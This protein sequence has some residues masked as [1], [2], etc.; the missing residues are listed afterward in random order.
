MARATVRRTPPRP[1]SSHDRLLPFAGVAEGSSA[2]SV[3]PSRGPVDTS[4]H[5]HPVAQLQEEALLS[6]RQ[7]AVDD[8]VHA[9]V[10]ILDRFA[11]LSVA[12]FARVRD[13]PLLRFR[14][15]GVST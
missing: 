15:L 1:A 10:R 11:F 12:A 14:L 3:C 6:G 5:A 9:L 4:H 7:H 13:G 8:V 2:M